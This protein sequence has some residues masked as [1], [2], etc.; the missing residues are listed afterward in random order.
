METRFDETTHKYYIYGGEVPSVTSLIGSAFNTY[1]AV[2]A[3]LLHRAA[4]FGT[5]VHKMCELHLAGDL[6]IDALDPLLIPYLEGFKKFIVQILSTHTGVLVEKELYNGKL[7]FAGKPDIVTDTAV[8]D[9][10]TR[11]YNKTT[12]PLQLD[13]YEKLAA[14]STNKLDHFVVELLPDDYKCTKCNDKNAW[15]V[16]KNLLETYW[17]NR[18]S[19]QLINAWKSR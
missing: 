6:D 8:F 2:P 7:M 18:R 19:Q 9:L 5:A 12:D 1:A 3:E 13:A 4:A 15:P 11:A 10:K 16:F 14:G 17:Q